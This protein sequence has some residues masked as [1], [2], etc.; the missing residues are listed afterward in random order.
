M[1]LKVN[2]SEPQRTNIIYNYSIINN[3]VKTPMSDIHSSGVNTCLS[4]SNKFDIC[5]DISLAESNY[6]ETV[7]LD[8]DI[9]SWANKYQKLINSLSCN[10][11]KG[12]FKSS[13]ENIFDEYKLKDFLNTIEF[14]SGEMDDR[15]IFYSLI[16]ILSKYPYIKSFNGNKSYSISPQG[17]V[18]LSIIK[19][20]K[21][22]SSI[23]NL[24]F[25]A[26][27]KIKFNTHDS[28]VNDFLL[29]GIFVSPKKYLSNRKFKLL[30]RL[31][32]DR[33]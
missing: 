15:I 17:F 2:S 18:N 33:F 29:H 25:C 8:E 26:D 7:Q 14:I 4:N 24:E 20:H 10:L 5:Y 23:L 22:Y 32:D 28:E 16:N 30:L 27:G 13:L 12:I 11:E 9:T 1:K 19:T 6:F 21:N 31:L 3:E